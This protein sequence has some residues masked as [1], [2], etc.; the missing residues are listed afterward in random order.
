[1]ILLIL[2][3]VWGRA[4]ESVIIVAG[5]EKERGDA[6]SLQS[7]VIKI[8]SKRVGKSLIRLRKVDQV[9]LV[10]IGPL[11]LKKKERALL[12]TELGR[13]GIAPMVVS[14]HD[15]EGSPGG[16]SWPGARWWQWAFLIALS[17]IGLVFFMKR[18]KETRLLSG[19]QSDLESRQMRLKKEMEEG[20]KQHG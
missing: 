12:L 1:M 6:Q 10:E 16:D 11:N 3:S 7:R 4:G 14:L 8:V 18:L 17:G 19:R 15:K 20:E 5:G 2:F 13:A 9:W